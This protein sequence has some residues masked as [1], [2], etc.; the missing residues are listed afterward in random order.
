MELAGIKDLER[1]KDKH[2]NCRTE[3]RSTAD[4][5]NTII[6]HCLKHDESILTRVPYT[7]FCLDYKACAGRSSCPRNYAC[8]E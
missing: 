8:S 7:M 1:F 6:M 3:A 2:I 4:A 5:K